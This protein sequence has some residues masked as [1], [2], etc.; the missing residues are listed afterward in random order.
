VEGL[1]S[2]AVEDLQC[3]RLGSERRSFL[4]SEDRG[5]SSCTPHKKNSE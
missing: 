1:R 4:S 2:V 5:V 3:G